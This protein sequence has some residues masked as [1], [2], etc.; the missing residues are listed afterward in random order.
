MLLSFNQ[1]AN[2]CIWYQETYG[3]HYIHVHVHVSYIREVGSLH[4]GYLLQLAV[5]VDTHLTLAPRPLGDMVHYTD[6]VLMREG[7]ES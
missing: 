3:T 4:D 7:R 5:D 2:L 1:P 6:V